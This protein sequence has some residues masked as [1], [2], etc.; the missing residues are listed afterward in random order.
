MLVSSSV[1]SYGV[2]SVNLHFGNLK[3]VVVTGGAGGVGTRIVHS[4][5][6][7]GCTVFVIDRDAAAI[8]T[9]VESTHHNT[10]LFSHCTD[11]SR[12]E[13]TRAAFE[14]LLNR[15]DTIE[16]LVCCA[17]YQECVS[18]DGLTLESWRNIFATNVESCVIGAQVI[19]R[20]M[21][22][23]GIPGSMLFITSIHSTRPRGIAHYSSSKSALE[24]FAREL[25][26]DLARNNIR[27]NTIAPGAIDTPLL[28]SGLA[29]RDDISSAKHRVP[30]NRLGDPQEVANLAM[31][32]L[33]EE[34]SYITGSRYI[35]DGGLS[36]V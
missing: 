17:G 36:L 27:V 35:I 33:S 16:G 20:H 25:A 9:L 29:N 24:M 3:S 5:L 18:I 31:F 10:A 22:E 26:I 4:L 19:S 1:T 28:R 13:E 12:S 32:L 14:E 23:R 6:D 7:L 21:I 30:L 2:N 8:D 34:A 11:L 15:T